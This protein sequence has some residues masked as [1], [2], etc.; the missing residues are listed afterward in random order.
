MSTS[1]NKYIEMSNKIRLLL[2]GISYI[3]GMNTFLNKY[4]ILLTTTRLR[5]Y[6]GGT[7]QSI[8]KVAINCVK[9]YITYDL[10]VSAPYIYVKADI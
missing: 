7:S 8:A 1:F 4:N 2:S 5:Q 9:Y 10:K 3:S 6:I